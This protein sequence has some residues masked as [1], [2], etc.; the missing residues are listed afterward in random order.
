M[1]SRRPR[2]VKPLSACLPLLGSVVGLAVL[3]FWK[4]G[5]VI[6]A[7]VAL[8]FGGAWLLSPWSRPARSVVLPDL[9]TLIAVTRKIRALRTPL[10]ACPFSGF[11]GDSVNGWRSQP[12]TGRWLKNAS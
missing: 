4:V 10:G 9:E 8:G 2:L 3:G 5:V 12:S 11:T 1:P 7:V 6:L